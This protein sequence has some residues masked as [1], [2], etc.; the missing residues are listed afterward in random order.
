MYQAL[1]FDNPKLRELGLDR[2]PQA[3]AMIEQGMAEL[4]ERGWLVEEE[5]LCQRL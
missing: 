5:H 3:G 4:F 1:D 2:Q